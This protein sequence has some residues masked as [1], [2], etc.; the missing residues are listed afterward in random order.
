M[1]VVVRR[2]RV[3]ELQLNVGLMDMHDI[4]QDAIATTQARM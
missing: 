3:G 4:G 2:Q 1:Q